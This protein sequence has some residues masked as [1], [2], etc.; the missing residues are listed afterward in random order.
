MT[1]CGWVWSLLLLQY[2]GYVQT[3]RV[4]IKG[5]A[6]G[7]KETAAARII[8]QSCVSAVAQNL[9]KVHHLGKNMPG[10]A[11]NG[12]VRFFLLCPV[13]VI[14]PKSFSSS[15]V[16]CGSMHFSNSCGVLSV[17]LCEVKWSETTPPPMPC[18]RLPA[19][20]KK[21]HICKDFEKLLHSW[22][23]WCWAKWPVDQL[24]SDAFIHQS[25]GDEMG[26]MAERQ[27][28][29]THRVIKRKNVNLL[30]KSQ[31]PMS[32]TSLIIPHLCD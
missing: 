18:H 27:D 32:Y 30:I 17:Q 22:T 3:A 26:L 28:E 11:W 1:G 29:D 15:S 25:H 10:E 12:S 19:L 31:N 23:I 4:H 9:E 14:L 2:V 6:T 7:I 24:M 8:D 16:T 20:V 21:T 13:L 5:N